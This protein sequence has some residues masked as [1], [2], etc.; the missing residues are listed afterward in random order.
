MRVVLR[1]DSGIRSLITMGKMHSY[2]K[3]FKV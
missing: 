1:K 2:T 3:D